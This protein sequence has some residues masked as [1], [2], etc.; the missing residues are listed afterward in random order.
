MTGAASVIGRQ[1][2]GVFIIIAGVCAVLFLV[3]V[4]LM[5]VFVFRYSRGRN[6]LPSNIEGHPVLEFTFLGASIVLV[7]A[8]FNIGWKGYSQLKTGVPE[9]A[10]TIEDRKSTRLNSSH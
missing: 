1:T 6:L 9:G 2:D 3:I 7:L 4:A 10:L 8:L 5:L